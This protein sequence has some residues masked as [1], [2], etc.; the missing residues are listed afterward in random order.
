MSIHT[1]AHVATLLLISQYTRGIWHPNWQEI[2][3]G[4][5]VTKAESHGHRGK[6]RLEIAVVGLGHLGTV[7]AAGLA[8]S[9]HRVL[10]LDVDSE[11][12][13]KLRSGRSHVY[14]PGLEEWLHRGLDGG[15]LRF[16]HWDEVAE[17]LGDVAMIATGTP[18][19][20][21]GSADISQVRSALARVKPRMRSD[22]TVVMKSTVPPGTGRSIMQS[23]LR[24]TGVAYVSNPEFLR[25]G[26]ALEDWAHPDRIVIG[27]EQED[28]RA[29]DIVRDMY[30]DI[31]AP[32]MLTDVNSAEMIKYASN[33]FLAT[34]ISF[35]NEIALLCD[36]VGAS[37]DAVSTGI[38]MD[39]RT[40]D[41]IRAGV[42]YGG[43]CLPKDVRALDYL[44][45]TN[46][47]ELVLLR[48]VTAANNRQR[49]LPWR[50]LRDRFRGSFSGLTVG[51][52]GLAFKPDTDDVREA[53]CLDLIKT[54]VNEGISVKAFDPRANESASTMLPAEV[55]FVDRPAEAAQ[56][57]QAMMLLT[58]WPDIVE[59]DW[60]MI[61]ARMCSPRFL[62]DGRNALEP[63]AMLELGFDYVGVGRGQ[64]RANGGSLNWG[65]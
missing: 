35:I 36:R 31:D 51:V 30:S 55:L 48:S 4:E 11:R 19:T 61:A 9:G 58:E 27:T 50:A 47:V 34:R 65:D 54:M 12:I 53:P 59:T 10:G 21:I 15:N 13:G 22:T 7:A 49:L 40:G 5:I 29:I 32:L 2:V 60:E 39:S 28:C 38:A 45:L 26:R 52:L 8:M 41:R 46:A 44:G 18:P 62:Y 20:D 14:E 56:G 23:E 3:G 1:F 43:S 25:E 6:S 37:I 17:P 57:A 24:G 16:L 42:G 64:L 63:H 33:A